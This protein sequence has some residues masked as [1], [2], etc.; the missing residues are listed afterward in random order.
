MGLL[1]V[2]GWM[3]IQQRVQTDQVVG[4]EVE[5]RQVLVL[6]GFAM[7]IH[8]R[9]VTQQANIAA[10]EEQRTEQCDGEQQN[11]GQS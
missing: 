4:D 11:C 9:E 5:R 2:P 7:G 1:I 10:R 3:C 6:R 8:R